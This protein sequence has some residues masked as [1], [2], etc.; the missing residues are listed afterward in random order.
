MA[1]LINKPVT[2]SAGQSLS[3]PVTINPNTLGGL[4]IPANWTSA[5]V[6]TFQVS[7]NGTDFYDLYDDTGA[8]VDWAVG[9]GNKVVSAAH[10]DSFWGYIKIRSGTVAAPVVQTST[11]AIQC[12]LKNSL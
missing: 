1:I 8:L 4:V 9:A 6:I 11:V 10:S 7:S 12:L 2:I 3:L 5:G